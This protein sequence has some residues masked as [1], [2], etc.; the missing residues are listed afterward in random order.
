MHCGRE[1]LPATRCTLHFADANDVY[2]RASPYSSFLMCRSIPRVSFEGA[3][4]SAPPRGACVVGACVVGTCVVFLHCAEAPS[5]RRAEQALSANPP[6]A[7]LALCAGCSWAGYSWAWGFRT[8]RQSPVA[9]P[10]VGTRVCWTL[11]SVPATFRSTI[12]L[13]AAALV[14]P[15]PVCSFKS[16]CARGRSCGLAA[17]DVSGARAS[18]YVAK[19]AH[20]THDLLGHLVL[21]VL[22]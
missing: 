15:R 22:E 20:S 13:C 21:N 18:D 17:S 11:T 3:S 16:N 7:D 2:A 5:R 10:L 4:M 1:G 12:E 8:S 6:F 14:P 9:S 19:H